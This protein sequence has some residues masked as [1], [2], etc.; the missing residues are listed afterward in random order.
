M[1][2]VGADK[3]QHLG[4]ALTHEHHAR[5]RI[6]EHIGDF[7]GGQPPVDRRHHRAHPVRAEES[8]EIERVV[9]AEEGHAVPR[10]HPQRDEA[11]RHAI[12]ALVKL[13]E[14]DVFLP[15]GEGDHIALR[16]G[17]FANDVA[18]G[19]CGQCCA[20]SHGARR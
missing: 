6:V 5:L 4:K 9:L 16:T 1:G 20:V 8:L 2:A 12:R 10:L 7:G 11:V 13:G 19:L 3:A 17:V 15:V 14:A 18:E